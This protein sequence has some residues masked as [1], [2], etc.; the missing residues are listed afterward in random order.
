MA[1]AR[2][3]RPLFLTVKEEIE[4]LVAER[5]LEP[6]SQLPSEMEL[7]VQLGVSRVTLREA[8]RALEEEGRIVRE[9]GLGTF[10]RESGRRVKNELGQHLGVTE[11]IE[12]MGMQA[13][14]MEQSIREAPAD[15]QVSECLRIP[16]GSPVLVIERVRTAD[17]KPVVYSLDYLPESVVQRCPGIYTFSGSLYRFLEQECGLDIDTGEGAV[18]PI[19]ADSLIARKLRV[20]RRSPLLMFEQVD[21]DL[22]GTPIVYGREAFATGAFRFI[23]RRESRSFRLSRT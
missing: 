13:G 7:S 15:P 3:R 4:R 19:S 9:H 18:A 23:F 22:T 14:T 20:P 5:G 1:V 10:V 6:G 12:G 11:L 2:T 17:A 8:L 16:I 21:C